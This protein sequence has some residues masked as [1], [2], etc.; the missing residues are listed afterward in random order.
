MAQKEDQEERIATLE[1]RYL[2]IQRE[3]ASVQD[4]NDRLQEDLQL[5]LT[6]LRGVRLT[7]TLMLTW[8]L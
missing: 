6:E 7:L 8:F 4:V 1:K 3:S 2:S 5:R